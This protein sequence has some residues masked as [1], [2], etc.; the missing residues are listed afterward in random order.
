MADD[1]DI[2]VG[3][4]LPRIRA[5]SAHEGFR[6]AVTW[7]SAGHPVRTQ[8]VDLA[9]ATFR[10]KIYLPLRDDPDLFRSIHVA[11]DGF[12]VAWHGD[13]IDMASTTI[14][15]LAEQAMTPADF[16]GFMKRSGYTL[17]SVAAELGISRRLAACYAKEREI[18]RHIALACRY[19][20]VENGS[21]GA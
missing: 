12:A 2:V 7:E 6:V 21:R 4:P 9:P 3:A 14:A 18:P 17:D 1:D 16:A 11:D 13:E 19:L 10:Y 20:E 5:I 15:D 8:A